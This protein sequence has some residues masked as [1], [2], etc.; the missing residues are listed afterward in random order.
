MPQ[1]EGTWRLAHTNL[2]AV[3]GLKWHSWNP[4]RPGR[5]WLCASEWRIWERAGIGLTSQHMCR[6]SILH[7]NPEFGLL[8]RSLLDARAL[9][10]EKLKSW[11][12]LNQESSI[13][14]QL[15]WGEI[16]IC[17]MS[18]RMSL[19]SDEGVGKRYRHLR[20]NLYR[21]DDWRHFGSM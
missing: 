19:V 16:G 14:T 6:V 17:L 4:I 15:R 20:P 7:V 5:V 8:G 9:I 1:G 12:C 18:R 2:Q 13:P 10:D 21:L 11:P 3:P